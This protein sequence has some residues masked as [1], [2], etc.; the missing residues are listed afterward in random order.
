MDVGA[1]QRGEDGLEQRLV[2]Q[3]IRVDLRGWVGRVCGVAFDNGGDRV[4]VI[5][6]RVVV[7]DQGQ[8]CSRG[9]WSGEEDKAKT[10]VVGHQQVVDMGPQQQGEDSLKQR[11]ITQFVRADPQVGRR[12]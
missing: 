5:T 9:Q 1:Q 11:L 4:M 2:T 3:F 12:E 7:L 8:E 6:T 10:A